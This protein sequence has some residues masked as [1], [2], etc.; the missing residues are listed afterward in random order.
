[1]L[2]KADEALQS[3]TVDTVE[4]EGITAEVEWILWA[5]RRGFYSGIGRAY[6]IEG[7]TPNPPFPHQIQYHTLIGQL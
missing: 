6:R 3:N 4:E 7:R 1:M 5:R 2:W